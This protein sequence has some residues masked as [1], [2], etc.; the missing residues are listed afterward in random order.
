MSQI[1]TKNATIVRT[2]ATRRNNIARRTQGTLGVSMKRFLLDDIRA[3]CKENRKNPSAWA[4]G[5]LLREWEVLWRG[6]AAKRS[7]DEIEIKEAKGEQ[8]EQ[9]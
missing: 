2:T 8:H 5:V 3:W 4:R 9:A 7:L 6:E 1:E